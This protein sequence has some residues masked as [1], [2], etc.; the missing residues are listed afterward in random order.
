MEYPEKNTDMPQ[1]TDKIAKE[2]NR[3][4]KHNEYHNI[5]TKIQKKKT[6]N[7]LNSHINQ[8]S[9]QVLFRK[10]S[11]SCPINARYFRVY[12]VFKFEARLAY[13]RNQ[14]TGI[15]TVGL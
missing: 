14:T 5:K 12:S 8:E 7:N 6:W 2:A 11:I 1:I 13:R 15:Q 10:I 3:I 4:Q 9:E